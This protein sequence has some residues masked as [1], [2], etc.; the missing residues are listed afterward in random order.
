MKKTTIFGLILGLALGIALTAYAQTATITLT[1]TVPDSGFTV[2]SID[3]VTTLSL[4][5]GSASTKIRIRNT[6]ATT[7]TLTRT[8]SAPTGLNVEL[9][10]VTGAASGDP[11]S[12][13]WTDTLTIERGDYADIA[14]RLTDQGLDPGTYQIEINIEG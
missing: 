10:H 2:G 14:I 4:A 5:D 9:A 7:Q 1:V 13:P 3:G 6:G 8:V 11:V 12:T